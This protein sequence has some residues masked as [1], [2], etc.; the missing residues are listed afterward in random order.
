MFSTIKKP[1]AHFPHR[2]DEW[3]V[4]EETNKEDSTHE[5][6]NTQCLTTPS[7]P[8]QQVLGLCKD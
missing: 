1:L 2:W 7:A 4:S 8:L 6:Q 3:L 5:P